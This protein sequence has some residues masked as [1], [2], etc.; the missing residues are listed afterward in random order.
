MSGSVM[1]PR[2]SRMSS[3]TDWQKPVQIKGEDLNLKKLS[4]T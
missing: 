3:G 2:G 1:R 4:N